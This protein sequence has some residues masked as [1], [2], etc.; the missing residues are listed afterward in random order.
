MRIV[1]IFEAKTQL[2]ALLRAVARGER[3]QIAARGRP[4][5]ALVPIED[6]EA[7]DAIERLL[8]NEARLGMPAREAIK[9]GRL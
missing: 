2:S 3:I 7:P 8:A 1:G 4:V 9:A 5:A 6:A